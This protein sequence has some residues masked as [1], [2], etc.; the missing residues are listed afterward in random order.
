MLWCRSPLSKM[1]TSCEENNFLK[2]GRL[3]APDQSSAAAL[4]FPWWS[5]AVQLR[6]AAQSGAVVGAQSGTDRVCSREDGDR[7]HSFLPLSSFRRS[8]CQAATLLLAAGGSPAHRVFHF[9]FIIP[10][11]LFLLTLKFNINVNI[12]FHIRFTGFFPPLNGKQLPVFDASLL[13]F[14]SSPWAL[15][16]YRGS[17]SEIW[18]FN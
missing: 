9:C 14:C 15:I 18:N 13:F 1:E 12:P 16:C 7:K 10:E 17:Q 5:A 2:G 4:R 3:M 11:R 6:H 8:S